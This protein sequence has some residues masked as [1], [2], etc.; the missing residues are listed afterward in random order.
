[1]DPLSSDVDD[2]QFT[3]DD[4]IFT[5]GS[6]AILGGDLLYTVE[7]P[8]FVQADDTGDGSLNLAFDDYC[9]SDY[10][11]VSKRRVKSRDTVCPVKSPPLYLPE[12]FRDL[13]E[14][15][16]KRIFGLFMCPTSDPRFITPHFPVCSSRISE[17][18]MLDGSSEPET[19]APSGESLL[20]YRLRD[21]F[22]S[23]LFCSDSSFLQLFRSANPGLT[24]YSDLDRHLVLHVSETAV[25]LFRVGSRFHAERRLSQNGEAFFH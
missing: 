19:L 20:Y 3:N 16:Q 14:T 17:N 11:V 6:S 9:P 12:N 23:R 1:M 24:D 2:L 5:T 10:T 18:T 22:M 7:S 8:V 21:S 4:S 25:L 13:S 15:L